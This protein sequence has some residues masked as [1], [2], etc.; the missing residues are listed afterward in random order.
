MQLAPIEVVDQI[1]KNN[2]TERYLKTRTPV[3]IRDFAQDWE[4]LSKWTYPYLKNRA[5]EQPVDLYG[6]WLDN[7]PSRIEMPPVKRS[8]FGEYL[9]LLESGTPSDLRIF[10]FNLFELVP[11]LLEDFTFPDITNGYLKNYP[12]LFFGAAGSDVRLH[13]DI[14][15]SNVFIT[16]FKGTKRITLFDQDQSK[17]LYKIP[18]STHSAVDLSKLDYKEYPALK[19]AK[20]YQTK[21]EHGETLFMPSGIWHYIQYLDSSFSLSLRTLAESPIGK[22]KGVFNVLVVRKLDEYLSKYYGGKWSDYKLR[23]A[24][25]STLK[26]LNSIEQKKAP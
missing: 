5:G 22:L 6:C 16:Q 25:N 7:E 26:I 14:D 10:L 4:A 18:F 20:G 11:S 12:Y 3:V 15:L 13:Y 9:S 24:M 8:S 1:S 21:L 19:M 17:Y 23:K 2:F